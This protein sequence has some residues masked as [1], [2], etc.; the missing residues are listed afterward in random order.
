MT[1]DKTTGVTAVIEN[2]A[3]QGSNVGN[4]FWHLR[5]I[6]DKVED[7]LVW[8]FAWILAIPIPPVMIL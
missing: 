3:G 4:E 6:I 2:T 5:Y 7:N 8:E 1:L